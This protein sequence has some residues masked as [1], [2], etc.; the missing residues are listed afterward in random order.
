[1]SC[2]QHATTQ[3]TTHAKHRL[4]S[5]HFLTAS[6]SPSVLETRAFGDVGATVWTIVATAALGQLSRRTVADAAVTVGI[7]LTGLCHYILTVTRQHLL[8]CMRVLCLAQ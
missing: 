5:D 2:N 3:P 1:M 4:S 7:V 6:T 8:Q